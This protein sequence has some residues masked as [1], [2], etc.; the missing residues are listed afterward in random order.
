MNRMQETLS[1]F[2][3]RILLLV[4]ICQVTADEDEILDLDLVVKDSK[5]YVDPFDL[6]NYDRRAM[7]KHLKKE[8]PLVDPFDM[9]NYDSK[10]VLREEPR[11]SI[12]PELNSKDEETVAPIRDDMLYTDNAVEL[13]N[14]DQPK[15]KKQL[16]KEKPAADPVDE[17]N[18]NIN[19]RR[20][21][22]AEGKLNS[23]PPD[24]KSEDD[25]RASVREKP[26]LGRFVQSLYSKLSLEVIL[27]I[28]LF[29]IP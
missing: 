16:K 11:H 18:Y 1:L 9:H 27:E 2:A 10:N 12:L 5:Q 15:I 29:K 28:Y 20:E 21:E 8:K 19:G 25:D 17:H 24:P 4:C 23:I 6:T 14:H 13:R 26:I 3:F 22:T 7:A